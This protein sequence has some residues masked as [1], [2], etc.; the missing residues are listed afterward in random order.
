MVRRIDAT[1][2]RAPTL[3][4]MTWRLSALLVL[5]PAC[6]NDLAASGTCDVPAL[7]SAPVVTPVA[8]VGGRAFFDDVRFSPQ[9][10]KVLATPEGSGVLFVVDPESLEVARA[11]VPAGSAS[12]DASADAI[13]LVDRFNARVVAIDA[14]TFAERGSTRIE[15]GPDYVRVAPTTGEVWVTVPGRDRIDIFDAGAATRIG[16]VALSGPPEG[17]T[18]GA[19]GRAYTNAGTRAATIDVAGRVVIAEGD[20]GC[21]WAH[22]FPQADETY[23]LVI[24]GCRDNGGAGVVEG[25]GDAVAG[26]E[27]GGGSA[28]LAYD[29]SRHHLYLRG[30]GS[31]TLDVIAVCAAGGMSVIA[32]VTI[33]NEGHASTVDDRGDVWVADA[34]DGGL[35]RIAE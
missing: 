27:A 31:D 18:F 33:P 17:L 9:L 21:G 20:T 32:S 22:G 24:G 15:G 11:S 2:G 19:D 3:V 16:S 30:D 10:G 25:T 4:D 6:G 14:A 8:L 28:V 1:P 34:V 7:P 5:A 29:P 23:G 26:I 12:V 13:Y 35:V